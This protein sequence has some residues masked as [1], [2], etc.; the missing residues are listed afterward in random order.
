MTNPSVTLKLTALA[1]CT[2]VCLV[3][4]SFQ[5]I[6]GFQYLRTTNRRKRYSFDKNHMKQ[7]QLSNDI[8]HTN[9]NEEDTKT[10]P[11]FLDIQEASIKNIK[12]NV[13]TLLQ[14]T[15]T[16]KITQFNNAGASPSPKAT[17]QVLIQ[18]TLLESQFDGYHAAK[19]QAQNLAQVYASIQRLINAKLSHEIAIVES[20][21]VG[22]TRIFYSMVKGIREG[23]VIL[24]SEV[25]YAANVVA[26]Q[27]LVLEKGVQLVVMPS[28]KIKEKSSGVVDV[29]TLND[30]LN[31]KYKLPNNQY[32]NPNRIYMICVTHIPTNCGI[33]NP[34]NEIGVIIENYNQSNQRQIYYL[35]DACQSIGQ[36]PI[37]VQEMKCTA[38]TASGRKYLRGPRGTGF[39]YIKESVCDTLSVDHIDH[40]STQLIKD[41]AKLSIKYRSNAQKFEFWES[42]ISNRLGLGAAI[43]YALSQ[44]IHTIQQT[45]SHLSVYLREKL[46]TIP[47]VYIHHD[48]TPT[49]CGIVTFYI[50]NHDSNDVKKI[51]FE[52]YGVLTSVVP[53]LS[54]PFDSMDS[55]FVSD[56]IDLV[57]VSLSY[58]NTVDEIDFFDDSLRAILQ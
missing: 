37:N 39:L 54:T 35:V 13:N 55:N 33:I 45:C 36:I 58:F 8:N 32:L 14:N 30:I 16:I 31:G 34:V 50:K 27:Q 48:N 44:D 22:W 56:N 24:C 9:P 12:D 23:D 43:D 19:I 49:Q 21:T 17:L 26:I 52:K 25:E 6:P 53:A 29:K 1:S 15:K 2:I 7:A 10:N 46:C 18:H 51:L 40:Y 57:R 3:S 47:D 5:A 38:L 4:S 20:A 42:N 41:D 11:S 28:L